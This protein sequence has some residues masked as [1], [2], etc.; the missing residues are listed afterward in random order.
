MEKKDN[1]DVDLL[2][3][4]IDAV[5]K[6][7]LNGLDEPKEI[8]LVISGGAFNGGYGYGVLLYIR[9]LEEQDKIKINRIS[10]CSIGSLLAVDHLSN[11]SL[12]L[13]ELYTG[14]QRCLRD[15][16]RLYVLRE[17]VEKVID[18][19]L[20]DENFFTK[21]K[22][23]LFITRTNVSTGSHEV[24]ENFKNRNDLVEAVFSSCYIPFLVDGKMRYDD[25][26]VD[27]IVPFLFTDSE[28]PSLY[29]DLM[30]FSKFHKMLITMKEV[31]P[32]GRIIDGA[33]DASKF[34]NEG[35][36]GICSWVNKWG[37]AQ[38][39]IFRLTYL[40]LYIVVALLDILSNSS[41]PMFIS[42]S[43]LYKGVMN[44]LTRLL[45]DMLFKMSSHD[46]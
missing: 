46:A 30:C 36:A 17:I 29:I 7:S 37:I 12:N 6:N 2:R 11:R 35:S 24:I 41:V 10:G 25:K 23:R 9:S 20:E 45:R 31:N 3:N 14:L 43:A 34:F 44:T 21:A 1:A 42:D 5:T 13:E 18:N 40:V 16:G 15:N 28:R 27:G 32:H 19:A 26:Y 38:I 22:G 4:Y 33:N 8:D 39:A